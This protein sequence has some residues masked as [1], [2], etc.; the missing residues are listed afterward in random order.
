MALVNRALRRD[1]WL[2]GLLVWTGLTFLVFTALAGETVWQVRLFWLF[3]PGADLLLT[4]FSWRVARL[5][6]GAIRRFWLVLTVTGALFA[7]GDTTQSVL[8]FLPG[9]WSTNGGSVQTVCLGIGMT[10]VVTAMLIHPH[11]N[12]TGRE[13]LGFWLD[14]A[15]VLVAG[16]VVAWCSLVTPDGNTRSDMLAVLAATGVAITASF[17]SVKMILSGNAPM[18]KAA[19]MPMIGAAMVMS[20]GM[21]LA[22]AGGE[23]HPVIYFVRYLP[24]VLLCAGPRV[25]LLLASSDRSAFGERRRKPY[26]LL[27]YGAM[28]VAFGVLA[29]ALPGGVNGRLWGVV[30]G[31]ALICAL[32][33][34]RQLVAFH[35]N[36][37]LIS[38]LR[39][40][41]S[42]LRHQAHFDGL[43][44]L[45]NR[46]HFSE[47]VEQA[48]AVT[49]ASVSVL[50]VDLDGFKAVNDTM[51]HAAGDALLIGV[52]DRLRGAIR[53]GDVAARLGGDEFAVLLPGCTPAEA[54]QTA[55]RI[56]AALTVPEQIDGV[57]V[58]AAA[59][60]GVASAAPGANVNSLLREAD[61][62]MYAAK[63]R[64]KGTWLRHDP[65]M[66]ATRPAR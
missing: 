59:S 35:D 27:P 20:V 42:R 45:A 55:V 49:P 34:W 28:V 23:T 10:A 16:A 5:A 1:P 18:H 52:A 61:I 14:S 21:F 54:D 40:H 31:L 2:L 46:G 39:E 3:Q 41:E 7:I 26:S 8:T 38:R 30:A 48:L 66:L 57:P 50:L 63:H 37:A 15:T 24:T 62:A 12:R 53:S 19:A 51:G 25:Q 4:I 36:Q 11:P 64:G 33:A 47:Q 58:R 44:G 22:P 56:L 43:T 60:I 65:S 32:V 17:A 13:R 9:Q 6:T 29:L